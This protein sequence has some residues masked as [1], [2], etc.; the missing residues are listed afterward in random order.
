[1]ERE[2]IS[3]E[4]SGQGRS[5]KNVPHPS[6]KAGYNPVDQSRFKKHTR[7]YLY[8]I[9]IQILKANGFHARA[10]YSYF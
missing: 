2:R 9:Y 6:S 5:V 3:F 10:N 4:T 1:L 8:C 7:N